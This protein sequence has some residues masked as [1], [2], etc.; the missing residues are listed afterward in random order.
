MLFAVVACT[1]AFALHSEGVETEIMRTVETYLESYANETL[2]YTSQDLTVNT[3]SD[4]AVVLP[5][6]AESL[7]FE[8]SG[9]LVSV[10]RMKENI[11]YIQAKAE[12]WKKTRQMQN[13]YRRNLELTYDFEE[14]IVNGKTAEAVVH[15]YAV[16]TYTNCTEPTFAETVY[17][18]DLVNLSGKWL[19]AD[20][21]DNDWFDAKFKYGDG[22]DLEAELGKFIESLNEE[23]TCVVTEPEVNTIKAPDTYSVLYNGKN[24]AAYAYTYSGK[25][26]HTDEFYNKMFSDYSDSNA[27]CMN[28]ASQCMW[29][30]FYGSQEE[31]AINGSLLPMDTE[32]PYKWYGGENDHTSSWNVTSGS[33]GFL[34]YIENSN[35]SDDVGMSAR[36]ITVEAG[37]NIIAELKNKDVDL[38]SLIGAVALVDGGTAESI[39]DQYGHAVVITDVEDTGIYFCG[40]TNNRQHCKLSDYYRYG[41]KIIIPINMRYGAKPLYQI[42]AETLRPVEAGEKATITASAESDYFSGKTPSINFGNLCISVTS[43]SGDNSTYMADIG[44]NR[45]N[46]L[47][48]FEERGLYKVTVFLEYGGSFVF[49]VRVV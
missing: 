15:E 13:I 42:K 41:V 24:A 34:G 31:N 38:N 19:I 3:V 44:V 29:A 18:V 4:S 22:F 9:E 35:K 26:L 27:D 48:T 17:T 43:P 10:A 25:I 1:S 16:F 11:S 28:F 39:S 49:Y 14:V 6:S 40:H 37:A 47:Y 45:L 30:G 8:L 12:Y 32:G 2:M 23:A 7:N 36:I 5:V 46:Y 20:M 33:T 21:T